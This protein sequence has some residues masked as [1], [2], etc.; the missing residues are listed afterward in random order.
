[1]RLSLPHFWV[2]VKEHNLNHHTGATKGG[3]IGF[4]IYARCGNL[5]QVP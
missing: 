3:H 2:A 1:M 4:A 5:S